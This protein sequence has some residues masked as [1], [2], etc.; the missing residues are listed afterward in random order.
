MLTTIDNPFNPFT[1]WREWY[2]FDRDA[3]Y[4]TSEL[5]ARTVITSDSLS[6]ADQDLAIEMAIDEVVKE[7]TLGLYKKIRDPN[8]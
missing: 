3:G 8:S 7:N 1:H 5:L 4:F 6:E 2:A